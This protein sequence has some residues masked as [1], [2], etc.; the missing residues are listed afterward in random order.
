LPGKDIALRGKEWFIPKEKFLKRWSA[1]VGS[2]HKIDHIVLVKVERV[3][4]IFSPAYDTGLSEEEI[5][6][7]W[8]GYWDSIHS[9]KNSTPAGEQTA[10]D[11]GRLKI[12]WENPRYLSFFSSS[13]YA[14]TSSDFSFFHHNR[15]IDA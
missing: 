5:I 7:W 12:Q 10:D 9:K 2:K 4:P 3:L 14:T 1:T 11:Y 13:L 8:I 6:D 15:I